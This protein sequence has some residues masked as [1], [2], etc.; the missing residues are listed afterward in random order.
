MPSAWRS[1]ALVAF[2]ATCLAGASEARRSSKSEVGATR[3]QGGGGWFGVERGRGAA[4]ESKADYDGRYSFVRIRYG[5]A[6]DFASMRFRREP[7]W[8]HDFP[9]ADFHFMKILNE[10]TFLS[11][12]VDQGNIRTLDDP[13]L[14]MFPVAYMSEPGFW[15]MDDAEMQG[16]RVYLQKGGFIIFD[17]FRE[18][19]LDNLI[20]QMKRVLPELTFQRLDVSHPIFHSFF[21][22]KSLEAMPGYYGDPEFYGLFEDND[23]QKR[24][25]AIAN[26][27]HDFGEYWEFSD[28][29]YVPV[30]LSNEAYKFG[31]NYV[32]YAMT[33]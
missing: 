26:Y 30:D 32:M 14:A 22:I 16:L 28:T 2:A 25:I 5:A 7:P 10:L 6:V 15:S 13:D 19:H 18:N 23:P 29:G 24:L 20:A 1:A 12:L 21:E 3:Q 17:D 31:V 8:A 27:N 11:T 4:A 33:H 9:R